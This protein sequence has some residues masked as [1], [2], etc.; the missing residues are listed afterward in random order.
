LSAVGPAKA[1][2]PHR[3]DLR[4]QVGLPR[5]PEL[6]RRELQD[7]QREHERRVSL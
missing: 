3:E 1:D 5:R 6:S 2:R 4:H 7:H